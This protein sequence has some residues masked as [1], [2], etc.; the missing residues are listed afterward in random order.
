MDPDG[1]TR[2]Y[3]NPAAQASLLGMQGYWRLACAERIRIFVP[4]GQ[5][6]MDIWDSST[7]Q[8]AQFDAPEAADASTA[9]LYEADKLRR[10]V[11]LTDPAIKLRACTLE[12]ARHDWT[13]LSILHFLLNPSQA[14]GIVIVGSIEQEV[15][16]LFIAAIK[17]WQLWMS[18]Y[19]DPRYA[20][21]FPLTL[22]WLAHPPQGRTRECEGSYLRH[23]IENLF[24]NLYAAAT[25]GGTVTR[26][27]GVTFSKPGAVFALMDA[28]DAE[29]VTQTIPADP[30]PHALFQYWLGVRTIRG[31]N[32]VTAQVLPSSQPKPAETTQS[33]PPAVTRPTTAPAAVSSPAGPTC[34][35]HMAFLLKCGGHKGPVPCSRGTLCSNAHRAL[36]AMTVEEAQEVCFTTFTKGGVIRDACLAAIHDRPDLFL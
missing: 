36:D 22:H 1:F 4:R 8:F 15:R 10:A 7:L 29:L 26:F 28:L 27:N 18:I 16:D 33:A 21:T 11:V 14:Q 6:C 31:L 19:F 30:F 2:Q 35:F 24:S 25:L 34:G 17:G 12:W 32:D 5:F 9:V 20:T 23:V 13:S 3:L